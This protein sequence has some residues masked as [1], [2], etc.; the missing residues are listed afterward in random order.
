[1][2]KREFIITDDSSKLTI[3][4]SICIKGTDTELPIDIVADFSDIPHSL[5][6]IYYDAIISKYYNST[7]I[8]NITETPKPPKDRIMKEQSWLE[9]LTFGLYK[10]KN[11]EKK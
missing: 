7:S 11:Y 1:M 4:S 5:H 3:N 6:Q 9:T 10:T 8:Y 2:E